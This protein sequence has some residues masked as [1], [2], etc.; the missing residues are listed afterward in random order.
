MG[1]RDDEEEV[2]VKDKGKNHKP[3]PANL[4]WISIFVAVLIV[5]LATQRRKE[6]VKMASDRIFFISLIVVIGF[7]VA[8]FLVKD[9]LYTK[10]VYV[11]SVALIIAIFTKLDMIWSSFYLIFALTM[12]FPSL[13]P[14]DPTTPGST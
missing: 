3:R 7:I 14:I 8:I 2:K 6:V 4:I 9:P 10:A 11:G 1:T 12:S 13:Q 5:S